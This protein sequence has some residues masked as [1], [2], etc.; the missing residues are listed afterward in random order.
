[1]Q[2][3]FDLGIAFLEILIAAVMLLVI[4]VATG[5]VERLLNTQADFTQQIDYQ[6]EVSDLRRFHRAN[7]PYYEVM[8]AIFTHAR[9]N[10]PV[11]IS[12]EHMLMHLTNLVGGPYFGWD[13]I[14]PDEI[15]RHIQL[16]HDHYHDPSIG[17][18]HSAAWNDCTCQVFRMSPSNDHLPWWITSP[19]Q[20]PTFDPNNPFEMLNWLNDKLRGRPDHIRNQVNINNEPRPLLSANSHRFHSRVLRD[21]SGAPMGLLFTHH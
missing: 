11:I 8:A 6:M 14:P 7:I 1:M 2:T 5:Q 18:G 4:L 10:F 17:V 16:H 15:I 19:A 3:P 12:S 9:Y 21:A 13:Y 20:N